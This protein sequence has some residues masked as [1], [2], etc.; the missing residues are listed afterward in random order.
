LHF[1]SQAAGQVGKRF[2]YVEPQAGDALHDGFDRHTVH[3]LADLSLA[4][5]A[6]LGASRACST[7]VWMDSNSFCTSA[8]L[9]FE[10][11]GGFVTCAGMNGSLAPLAAFAITHWIAACTF[12]RGGNPMNSDQM[13]GQWKQL[14]GKMKEKWGKLT[15]SDWDQVAGRRDQFLGKLQERY[16]YS[17]DQAEREFDEWNREQNR[18]SRVA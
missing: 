7:S 12:T 8:L 4:E 13:E 6:G 17:K 16:G 3:R 2:G 18:T 10:R 5:A 15:D 9:R 1:F 11:T 14:K